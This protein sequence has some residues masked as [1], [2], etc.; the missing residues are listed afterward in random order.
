MNKMINRRLIEVKMHATY[1]AKMLCGLCH[2]HT[3]DL[4]HVVYRQSATQERNNR[5]AV[6]PD[7]LRGMERGER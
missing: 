5:A 2:K 7:C 1:P 4:Y 6:C 3:K